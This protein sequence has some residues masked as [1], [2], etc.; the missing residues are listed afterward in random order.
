MTELQVCA[1]SIS[2]IN[3]EFIVSGSVNIYQVKFNFSEEWEGLTKVVVFSAGRVNVEQ[4][5]L[6]ENNYVCD[7]PWEVI[8]NPHNSLLIG[9]YGTD[10][11]GYIVRPTV[12][13]DVGPVV[14]GVKPSSKAVPPSPDIYEQILAKL[15]TIPREMTAEELRVI[16][17]EEVI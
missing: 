10:N 7:V 15:S 8:A 2:V 17:T 16:L 6:L 3:S 13:I 11:D 12:T 5:V 4:D 9:V 14:R 1:H